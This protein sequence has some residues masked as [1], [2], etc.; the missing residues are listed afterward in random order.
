VY[1]PVERAAVTAVLEVLRDTDGRA[2]ELV[3]W[4]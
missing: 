4:V 1:G 3:P 2:G